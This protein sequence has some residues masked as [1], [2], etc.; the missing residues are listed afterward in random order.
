V[1][2][3][4]DIVHFGYVVEGVGEVSAVPLL[5][6]RI[7]GELF[8]KVALHG[9]PPV[10]V[11]KSKLIRE[12][13][14][15]RA[16][17][18]ARLQSHPQAA[19]LV[20]LDAD[21]DCPAVLGPALHRRALTVAQNREVSIIVAK[22][23]FEVWFLASAMSLSGKRGLNRQLKEPPRPETIRGA[24]EW[25]TRH[26]EAG[27]AYSPSVDQTALVAAMDLNAAR[28]CPSFDRLCRKLEGFVGIQ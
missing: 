1:P 19:L 16:L 10:R 5:V 9:S 23:E 22:F 12:G 18:L 26:M 3:S 20:V 7:C 4:S 28:A 15:E 17:R 24:K 2:S 25:L 8:G 11:T 13:E 27:R 6:R 21:D 14:L